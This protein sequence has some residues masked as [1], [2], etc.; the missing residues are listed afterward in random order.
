MY[1]QDQLFACPCSTNLRKGYCNG[2]CDKLS[3]YLVFMILVS[4]VITLTRS[5]TIFVFFRFECHMKSIQIRIASKVSID[6]F[7]LDTTV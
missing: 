1:I 2:V 4:F 5:P 6:S 3:V 7:L